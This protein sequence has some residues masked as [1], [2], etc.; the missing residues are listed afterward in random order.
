MDIRDRKE[1][2]ATDI[3]KLTRLRLQMKLPVMSG[4]LLLPEWKYRNDEKG[5]G[6][7]GYLSV[8]ESGG[9]APLVSRCTDT[10]GEEISAS[11]SSLPV[12]SSA[13][14]TSR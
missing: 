4:A 14:G 3:L 7:D 13:A 9:G 11:G 6:T 12:S 10:G 8:L 2:L 1:Q 5:T